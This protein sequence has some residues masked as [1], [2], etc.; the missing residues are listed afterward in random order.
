LSEEEIQLAIDNFNHRPRKPEAIKPLMN[1]LQGSQRYYW[2]Q[3]NCAYYLN[4]RFY[5][6]E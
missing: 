2:R 6:S 4:S 5:L 1:Y 3:K